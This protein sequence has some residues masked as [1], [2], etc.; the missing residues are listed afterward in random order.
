MFSEFTT[1]RKPNFGQKTWATKTSRT[2][3]VEC[4]KTCNLLKFLDPWLS[5][6]FEHTKIMMFFAL[7]VEFL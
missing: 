1:R 5:G 4:N 6:T 7:S 2:Y 3:W